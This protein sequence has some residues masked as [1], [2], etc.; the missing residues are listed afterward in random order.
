M[1]QA[2]LILDEDERISN[3]ARLFFHKKGEVIYN[4]FA[5]IVSSLSKIKEEQP[6]LLS[7]DNYHKVMK[8]LLSYVKKETQVINIV[9]KLC[10]RFRNSNSVS[11]HR[12]SFL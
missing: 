3:L 1:K 7:S 11:Q 9:D 2:M 12:G 6:Q 5:D 10:H 8:F 4:V